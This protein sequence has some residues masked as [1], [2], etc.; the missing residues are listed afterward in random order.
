MYFGQDFD[1]VTQGESGQ[2]GLNFVN[3]LPTGDTISAVSFSMSV[4][5]GT[6]TDPDPSS[7]LDGL[8]GISGTTV[9][10]RV[11]GLLP[12]L[13]YIL[14]ATVTTGNGN[15]IIGYSHISCETAS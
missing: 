10:Q 8:P 2:Y 13:T 1:V 6:G 12:G 7:H 9:L 3:D 4:V 14:L 5:A 11:N 15:T